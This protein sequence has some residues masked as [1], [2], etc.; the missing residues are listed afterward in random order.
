MPSSHTV[1]KYL[2]NSILVLVS[3]AFALVCGEFGLRAFEHLRKGPL[4]TNL[5]SEELASHAPLTYGRIPEEYMRAK[6]GANWHLPE[7][8]MLSVGQIGR[9][10]EFF[11]RTHWNNYACHDRINYSVSSSK[12]RV[13]FLGDSFV[14]AV[15]VTDDQTFFA[16]LRRT[17][18]G[19]A[20]DVAG[21]GWSG[22]S[23]IYA[24]HNLD[25]AVPIPSDIL[26]G[27]NF[28]HLEDLSSQ[29]VV[30]FI[31]VGNDLRDETRAI[32]DAWRKTP[33]ICRRDVLSFNTVPPFLLLDKIKSFSH[34]YLSPEPEDLRCISDEYWAYFPKHVPV[35]EAGYARII[36][37]LELLK[38]TVEAKG[39]KLVL[40]VIEPQPIAY[41]EEVTRKQLAAYAP[42]TTALTLDIN[43]PRVRFT[44]IA[45]GLGTPIFYV[46]D[47]FRESGSREHYYPEDG[48]LNALGHE[49]LARGLEANL[50]AL[51][52]DFV[53]GHQGF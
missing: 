10:P 23:P 14:E 19:D 24:A 2:I 41:G 27:G 7:S 45:H 16:Q 8:E 3:L 37:S 48:H 43:A 9:A 1:K 29:V 32:F 42:F 12:P 28:P 5:T 4:I 35:L 40:G 26:Q 13:L 6:V 44:E 49:A 30:Y 52:R 34:R 11:I 47:W 17:S 33:G 36:H 50:P 46:S 18:F 53:T 51:I 15:Q 31:F 25:P 22:W 39:A 20:F 38:K 21:C